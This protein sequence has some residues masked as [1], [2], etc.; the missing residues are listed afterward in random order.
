MRCVALLTAVLGRNGESNRP[1]CSLHV[2]GSPHARVAQ[3]VG[4]P[5]MGWLL[6][7]LLTAVARAQEEE[8]R[9]TPTGKEHGLL[10]R[11]QQR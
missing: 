10:R 5:R 6:V 4:V 7:L 3:L 1:C 9:W 8:A 2:V 11:V